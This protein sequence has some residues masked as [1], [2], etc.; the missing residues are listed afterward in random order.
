MCV[1]NKQSIYHQSGVTQARRQLGVTLV[2][3][4]VFMVI[5][6][7]AL[8]GVLKVLDITNRGSAD[9][10]VR[11]QALSI[12]ESLLLEI[13]Q[14]PFT[15]CDPDDASISTA[16]SAADCTNSQDKGGAALASPTPASESRYSSTDPFDNVAD[17]GG[18]TMPGGGCM[19]ICSPGNTTPLAGLDGYT[20][21]VTVTRAGAAAPFASLALDDVLKI[22]VRVTGP[23][24]TDVTLTGY[25]VRYAPNI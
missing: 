2:E 10:L 4:V 23:A 9:P 22:S 21:A 1:N 24:N 25:R 11:K 12:A 14:Q 5:V 8:V 13:Q 6:S 19:G 16:T 18:F 3:L 20:A 7:V 17:Y 15:Y